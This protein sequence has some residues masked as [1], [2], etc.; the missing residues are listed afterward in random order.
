[1]KTSFL[2]V[3]RV[4]PAEVVLEANGSRYRLGYPDG[5]T[6]P[7]DRPRA[8]SRTTRQDS[9]AEPWSHP[10]STRFPQVSQNRRP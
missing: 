6:A 7:V 3:A 10:V 8:A 2:V 9:R 4:T 5:L 1:M